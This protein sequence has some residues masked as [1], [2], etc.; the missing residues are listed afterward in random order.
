[1]RNKNDSSP[2]TKLLARISQEAG[3][4]FCISLIPGMAGMLAAA[5]NSVSGTFGF[6]LKFRSESAEFLANLLCGGTGFLSRKELRRLE[7]EQIRCAKRNKE[8]EKALSLVCGILE[9]DAE[10]AEALL[11]KAMILHEGFDNPA[12]ARSCLRKLLRLNPAADNNNWH[13]W[14][15]AL[16]AELASNENS[17]NTSEQVRTFYE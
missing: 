15:A 12:S 16:Y 6:L 14:G 4:S 17:A 1:M 8:Y 13:R 7:L 11:L 5:L 2:L 10:C 9:T 3:A